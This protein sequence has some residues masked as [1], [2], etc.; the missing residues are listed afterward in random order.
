MDIVK[1][2]EK[3]KNQID[4]IED[5]AFLKVLK[6]LFFYAQHKKFSTPLSINEYNQKLEEAELDYA[7]GNVKTQKD[8]LKEVKSWETKAGK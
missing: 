3:L 6:D 1:E 8:V 5:E 7:Q 4:L 2:K